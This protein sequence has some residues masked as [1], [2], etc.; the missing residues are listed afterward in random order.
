MY[1]FHFK[2]FKHILMIIKIISWI[3]FPE[4]FHFHVVPCT[5]TVPAA[6]WPDAIC[7]LSRDRVEEYEREE[8]V[9]WLK[10]QS[11]QWHHQLSQLG[12]LGVTFWLT[13]MRP[14][15]KKPWVLYS[16]NHMIVPYTRVYRHPLG[17]R[18]DRSTCHATHTYTQLFSMCAK[19]RDVERV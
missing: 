14:S 10:R 18:V 5:H 19:R 8:V 2:R 17:H 4:L 7:L 1:Q 13:L 12:S 15:S 16:V 3:N 11:Y 9:R 6:A